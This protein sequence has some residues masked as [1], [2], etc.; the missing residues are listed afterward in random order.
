[1]ILGVDTGG[2]FT[3]F[4]LLADGD[5]RIHKVL[6]TPAAPEQAII[7]GI[8]QLGLQS[9][10]QGGE[11]VLIHGSTVATN[12]ALEGKGVR[13]AFITNHGLGDMLTI[14]RQARPDLYQLQPAPIEPPVPVQ[15]CLETGGRLDFRGPLLEP[16]TPE[17][18]EQ[19][20][21][22][23]AALKPRAVA[24][25]LLYSFVDD[26]YEK[27]IEA[28]MPADV[29]VTRS[30]QVLPE[31]KEYERGIATWLNAW[32]GPL[33]NGYLQRLQ[34]AVHPCPVTIMQSSGGTMAAEQAA[35]RAVNMLLSGPAGGLAGAHFMGQ[36]AG[37]ARLVTFDMG[38]TSTDVALVDGAIGLTSE[39]RIGDWPVAVPMV[40]MHTIGAGGGSIARVDTGGMLH[41][42]PESAGADPGPAAYGLG[43]TAATVTDANLVLGRLQ[44]GEFLGGN[45]QLDIDAASRAVDA[46]ATTMQMDRGA[47]AEGIVRVANEHM[48]QALRKI[49]IERGYDPA[50]F[51]LCC[52]GGAGGLHVCE[53]AEQLGMSRALI[54]V[55]AGVL[56]ALGMLVAPRQRQLS[57]TFTRKL[58]ADAHDGIAEGLSKLADRGA[59]ELLAE[60][61]EPNAITSTFSLDLRYCGQSFTLNIPW[62]GDVAKAVEDF[63][64]CHRQRYGHALE[65]AV[66][67]VNLRAAICADT[68]Q[69]TLPPAINSGRTTRHAQLYGVDAPVAVFAREMLQIDR[70]YPGP[71]LI[72]EYVSTTWVKPGWQ[73]LRDKSGSLHLQNRQG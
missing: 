52:F 3:D 14:G 57:I 66:E 58:T 16:L 12:A 6:S 5:I 54:P 46:L 15:L 9:A 17:D 62:Y 65:F 22:Q 18:I 19:L 70:V 39:G 60:G 33:V 21:R 4:V 68:R 29:F 64:H 48:A 56:S 31:Y 73:V 26:Q 53:L 23:I 7:A 10:L 8:E 35:H 20:Q 36:Q 27:Q 69:L 49:S 47:A 51:T 37:Q 71:I 43:G 30:S 32:L 67:V 11:L 40:D 28:A 44:P 55:N 38:G 42:G 25:N 1:M 59:A 41:V 13:T 72:T 63:H 45:M 50:A 24:I 34:Q 61:V 2:T